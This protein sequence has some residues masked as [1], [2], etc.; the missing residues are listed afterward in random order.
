MAGWFT[1]TI[2][3]G[4]GPIRS[5]GESDGFV[6]KLD[7]YGNRLWSKVFG[8]QGP[9]RALGVAVDY[10][11]QIVVTGWFTDDVD[12]GN[13]PVKSAG[14]KD[15]FIAA[16]S[17][18]GSPLWSQG[19][20]GEDDQFGNG[21]QVGGGGNIV[22]TGSF[23]GTI[24]FGGDL[25]ETI[26]ERDVFVV[27]L[28]G[29]GAP[30]WSR[31]FGGEGSQTG[32]AVAVDSGEDV[33]VTG[34]FEGKLDFGSIQLVSEGGKDV[35]VTKLDSYGTLMWTRRFGD[36]ADQSGLGV[37][38][39]AEGDVVVT[40][41]FSGK[42]DF[43][44]GALASK[45][46]TDAFLC[47]LGAAGEGVLWS[48]GFGDAANQSG[49]GVAIDAKGN[50]AV[51]GVLEGTSDFGGGPLVSQGRSDVFVAEVD[52]SG[53]HLWSERFG[54]VEGQVGYAVAIDENGGIVLAGGFSGNVQFGTEPLKSQGEQDIFVAKFGP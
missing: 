44:S 17:P 42:I 45:G 25:L 41:A 12:F 27:E 7:P 15:V 20:G 21:V 11:F 23:E 46:G 10:D 14:G 50:V 9:D 26:D 34:E 39:G 3:L 19:F 22:V 29:N 28:D 51:T 54:D 48:R 36:A 53:K 31:S 47:K 8:G 18:S 30:L 35:F 2:D 24:E 40:G 37:A 5:H 4:D 16:F 52:A 13:G 6:L 49:L 43:G 32:F 38:V 1:E 33:I